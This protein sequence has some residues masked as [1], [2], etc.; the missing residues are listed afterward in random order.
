[1]TKSFECADVWEN[2]SWSADAFSTYDLMIKIVEHYNY[3]HGIR[4]I[5]E[6]LKAKVV[7]SIKDE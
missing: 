3:E 1:M 7:D 6:E 5:S 4:E 2:C